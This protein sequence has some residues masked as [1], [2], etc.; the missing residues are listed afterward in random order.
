MGPWGIICSFSSLLHT[1]SY[2]LCSSALPLLLS[3][4]PP[5]STLHPPLSL[6]FLSS[7]PLLSVSI[8][9]EH[10]I[11]SLVSSPWS[12]SIPDVAV[13]VPIEFCCIFFS[14]CYRK[15]APLK[16]GMKGRVIMFRGVL[17]PKWPQRTQDITLSSLFCGS[18]FNHCCSYYQASPSLER[19]NRCRKLDGGG[20][21]FRRNVVLSLS[22]SN[23]FHMWAWTPSILFSY[24]SLPL[25]PCFSSLYPASIASASPH[26][27]NCS[28]SFISLSAGDERL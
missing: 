25:L 26:S 21:L 5:P 2:S 20:L 17:R 28:L 4:N 12:K 14:L 9:S 1:R 10:T 24:F 22:M 13:W 6:L 15:W 16:R 19:G 27:S 7:S 18:I 23:D 11:L 3:W 8:P